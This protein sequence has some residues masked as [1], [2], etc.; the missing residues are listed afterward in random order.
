MRHFG[1]Q[2]V[3]Q[4]RQLNTA[5]HDLVGVI[6]LQTL[7]DEQTVL[8]MEQEANRVAGSD[9]AAHQRLNDTQR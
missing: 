5:A 9:R 7:S 4:V 3:E 1:W 8:G 6:V 2:S